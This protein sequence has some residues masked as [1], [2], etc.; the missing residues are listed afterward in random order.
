MQAF[1]SWKC[2]SFLFL[3]VSVDFSSVATSIGEEGLDIGHVDLIIS[4]D[5]LSSQLRIVQR[6][7]RTGRKRSGRCVT[8]V[9]E[10]AEEAKY[11]AADKAKHELVS[12]LKN[13]GKEPAFL[14]KNV[15]ARMLPQGITPTVQFVNIQQ[16]VARP[17]STKRKSGGAAVAAAASDSDRMS[18]LLSAAEYGRVQNALKKGDEVNTDMKLYT[19]RSSVG[20][21][22]CIPHSRATNRLAHIIDLL[23]QRMRAAG[24]IVDDGGAATRLDAEVRTL[25]A[26][27]AAWELS[28]SPGV[29]INSES[30]MLPESVPPLKPAS[31]KS[32]AAPAAPGTVPTPAAVPPLSAMFERQQQLQAQ[33]QQAARAE[34]LAKKQAET[35]VPVKDTMP[36]YS[37]VSPD[38]LHAPTPLCLR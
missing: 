13:Q 25:D 6:F 38:A 12:K 27:A 21:I 3:S 30:L 2:R 10:G 37:F 1:H 17:K 31:K 24:E 35:S 16:H 34:R 20:P 7:G 18:W 14:S 4:Y 9:M 32:T 28:Q 5:V 23:E 26:E 11:R 19:P 8:L 22:Y 33:K 29:E 15:S 36:M